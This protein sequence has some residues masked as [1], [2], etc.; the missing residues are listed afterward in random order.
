MLAIPPLVS[1]VIIVPVPLEPFLFWAAVVCAWLPEKPENEAGK[2]LMAAC[3]AAGGVAGGCAAGGKGLGTW[4][5]AVGVDGF[6]TIK[7]IAA[8]NIS[9]TQSI[10]LFMR[11]CLRF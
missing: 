10:V 5:G 8:P 1:A 11:W 2:L 3:V 9:K 6:T 7:N 4:L